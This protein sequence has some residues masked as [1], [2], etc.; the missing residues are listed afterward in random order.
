MGKVIP[1]PAQEE[2][3]DIHQE[4]AE[5]L[6]AVSSLPPGLYRIGQP[7][8][9]PEVERLRRAREKLEPG[10]EWCSYA[11]FDPPFDAPKLPEDI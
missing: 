7:N 10:L 11:R 1:F 4:I 5:A 8:L 6:E 2:N 3:P 9:P